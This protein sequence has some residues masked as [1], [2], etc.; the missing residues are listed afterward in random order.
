MKNRHIYLLMYALIFFIVFSYAS[1]NVSAAKTTYSF[2]QMEDGDTLKQYLG[3]LEDTINRGQITEIDKQYD[4]YSN[5][6]KKVE[7]TIGKVPGS[8]NRRILLDYY[9]TPAKVAKERVIYEVS[10]YRLL[11]KLDVLIKQ[12]KLSEAKNNFAVLERLKKR[13]VDI[14]I[15]GNYQELPTGIQQSLLQLEQRLKEDYE[16]KE[17]TPNENIPTE[18]TTNGD[19]ASESTVEAVVSAKE[20]NVRSEPSLDS[21]VIG[22]LSK[23]D[24]ITVNE[25]IGNWAKITF[26]NKIGY[27][28]KNYLVLNSSEQPTGS[29]LEGKIITIDPGH[30]GKQPGAIGFGLKE[31]DVTLDIGLKVQKL[32]EAEGAKIV[33][34]RTDDSTVDL[35]ERTAIAINNK[36]NIFVSLHMNSS[37][38]GSANGTETYWNEK[39]QSA[40]SKK[41]AEKI[42][43]RLIE[44]LNTTNRGVKTDNFYVI[45]N[46][47]MPSVLVEFGFISNE[48]EAQKMKT[49]QF[50]ENAAEAIL[51]G[52]LDYY[53]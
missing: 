25:F 1:P 53:K 6:I 33:M 49:D 51:L 24:R 37:T 9:I 31:K 39:Y 19:T 16:T 4:K 45:K 47:T 29:L 41:L 13:A 26:N 27:V 8:E 5:Q 18:D 15:A 7:A 28:H 3:E 40:E 50:R 17:N 22:K 38:S 14:K 2:K 42:Q 23:G 36:S 20:L 34:T 43:K 21:E 44:L 10:Q 35:P 11:N 46:T 32:L 30:G 52:I 12:G 48:T